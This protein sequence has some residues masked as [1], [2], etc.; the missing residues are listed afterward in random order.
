ML[1]PDSIASC[2][3]LNSLFE[4]WINKPHESITYNNKPFTINH[5]ENIFIPDGIVNETVWNSG[6]KK[7]ILFILKEAYGDDW[8]GATL[9]TWLRDCYP[10]D[11]I[12]SRIARLVYGIQNTSS[13]SIQKYIPSLDD[14]THKDCLQQIAVMNLKKSNGKSTS[15]YD[16][17]FAYSLIDKE[18]IKKE[19]T[20]IDADIIICGA[21]FKTLL[22][23]VYN[24]SWENQIKHSDNWYYYLNLDGKERL[25]ID[26]YHPANHWPD[27]MNYYA[28]ISIYQL[29]LKEK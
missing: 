5:K 1:H 22:S 13:D 24:I 12:W 21:T 11:R 29:A 9:A 26:F 28:L 18:E 6:N 20:L 16:E 10:K 4:I 19:F 23:A 3:D 8:N 14:E 7:R 25:F 27:L 15:D 17:I 2:S